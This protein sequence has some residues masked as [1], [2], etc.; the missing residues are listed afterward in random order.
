MRSILRYPSLG[1]DC[2][3]ER[4]GDN[5]WE[6]ILVIPAGAWFAD[7]IRSYTGLK[8]ACNIYKCGDRLSEPHF[9]S[10]YPIALPKPDFHC[11]S[12]FGP[13]EFL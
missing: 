11:P 4:R 2:F 10:L 13:I 12:F 6:L 9:I 3:E 8:G 5:I 1:T 7:G